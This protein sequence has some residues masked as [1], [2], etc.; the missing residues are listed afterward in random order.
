MIP[1]SNYFSQNEKFFFT[2]IVMLSQGSSSGW[3]QSK[4]SV[5]LRGNAPTYQAYFHT[6]F[7]SQQI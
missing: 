5:R 3:N 1:K 2:Y 4:V 7:Y 6:E